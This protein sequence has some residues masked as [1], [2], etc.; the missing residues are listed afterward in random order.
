MEYT[1]LPKSHYASYIEEREGAFIVENEKG[2]ATYR[3]INDGCYIED[4]YVAKDFRK[5]GQAVEFADQIAE[6]A[7]AKG[8]TRLYGTVAIG[9]KGATDSLKVLLAYGF[10]LHSANSQLVVFVKDL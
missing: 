5:N 10:N 3:F 7:K 1:P 8:F 9:A 2:F 4:I 6:I